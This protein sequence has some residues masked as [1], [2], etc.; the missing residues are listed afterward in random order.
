MD[1]NQITSAKSTPFSINDILT[2]HNTS[3]FQCC[4]S[5]NKS[6][7]DPSATD[8]KY[9]Q[10]QRPT[11]QEMI[12]SENC[13]KIRRSYSCNQQYE[14][15]EMKKKKENQ[16]YK[17]ERRGSLDCFLID[18]NHNFNE[19]DEHRAEHQKYISHR[20]YD[21]PMV[22]GGPLDMRRCNNDSGE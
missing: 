6:F 7:D 12:N 4:I 5:P 14:N 19:T 15:R 1:K 9:E 21:L 16:N 10:M 13:E 20:F 18:K 11:K 8:L 22:V 3:I 17:S 2:K